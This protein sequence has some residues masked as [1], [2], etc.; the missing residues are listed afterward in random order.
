MG[1]GQ[2]VD[3][4]VEGQERACLYSRGR[5]AG[6]WRRTVEEPLM[7]RDCGRWHGDTRPNTMFQ[8]SSLQS[9][10]TSSAAFL[11]FVDVE[12]RATDIS[13]LLKKF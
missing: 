7:F 8:L 9:S 13:I 10:C 4:K 3:C 1:S 12:E 11:D 2:A 6:W 5:R